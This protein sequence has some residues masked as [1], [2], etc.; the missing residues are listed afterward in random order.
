MAKTVGLMIRRRSGFEVDGNLT[1]GQCYQG[2]LATRKL[3]YSE[4]FIDFRVERDLGRE[5]SHSMKK[6]KI[7]MYLD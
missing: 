7:T 1:S 5:L 6:Q 4:A 2:F 3:L